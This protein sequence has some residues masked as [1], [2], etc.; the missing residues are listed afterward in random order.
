MT[1]RQVQ[2]TGVR[3]L[4]RVELDLGDAGVTLVIGPNGS[5]KTSILEA[6]HLLAV[7]RSFRSGRAGSLIRYGTGECTVFGSIQ[8]DEFTYAVGFARGRDGRR[9]FRVNGERQS[10]VS[11]ISR[12]LPVQVLGTRTVDLIQEGPAYRRRFLNWGVFHVEPTFQETW[13]AAERSLKH[14]NRLLRQALDSGRILYAMGDEYAA[15]ELQLAEHAAKLEVQRRSYLEEF[16]VV[17]KGVLGRIGLNLEVELDFYSGWPRVAA[18]DTREIARE[19]AEALEDCR[20]ADAHRGFTTMGHHRAD[21]R[22]RADG[23]PAVDYLSRGQLKLLAWAMMVSQGI[24][25]SQRTHHASIYLA[26]DLGAELDRANVEAVCAVL[27][28][29]GAQCVATGLNADLT[30]VWPDQCVGA[31]YQMDSGVAI[32]FR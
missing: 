27:A 9:E 20:P 29:S 8:R 2:I 16:R 23:H 28:E 19:L 6:L 12:L 30:A 14:R 31:H 26:D 1:L 25:V 7:G 18:V 4:D 5:G 22:I 13:A 3:N 11:E 21:L 24:L 32:R 10:R 15:W 17:L